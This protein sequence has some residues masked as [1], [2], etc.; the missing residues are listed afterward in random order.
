MVASLDAL[1]AVLLNK[2]PSRCWSDGLL[3]RADITAFQRA[4]YASDVAEALEE[5]V[6]VATHS[7]A[8][9]VPT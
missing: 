7:P 8:S 1:S 5:S 6:D 9:T 2:R 3:K 4:R